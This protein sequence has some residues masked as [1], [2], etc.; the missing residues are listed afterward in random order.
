MT[1]AERQAEDEGGRGS[2]YGEGSE[3]NEG[4]NAASLNEGA[5]AI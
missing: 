2:P 5:G 4:G 1:S 3:T